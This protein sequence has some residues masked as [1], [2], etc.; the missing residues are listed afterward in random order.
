MKYGILQVPVF[1]ASFRL[2]HA[3]LI[4]AGITWPVL[5]LLAQ[6]TTK[7]SIEHADLLKLANENGTNFQVLMGNAVLRQD[8]TYFYCDTARLDEHNNLRASGKVHI[9]YNDSVHLYGDYL[10]YDGNTRIAVMDSNVRLIDNRA[11]LYTDN[12]EYNRNLSTANYYTG[13]RIED[14]ENVL[15]SKIGRY[16]TQTYEFLFSDSVVVVNPDYT[17]YADTLKY[18]TETEIVFI[19]GPTDLYGNEDHIY[20]EKGWYDTRTDRAELSRNNRIEHLEQ[21]LKGDWIYYDGEKEYGKAIGNVWIKDTVQNIILEGGISE[22][23]RGEK[24]SYM[25]DSARAI[26]VD[27][28]DSLYMHADSLI[29][30]MDSADNAKLMFAYNRMKFFKKD[31]QGMCDSLVFRVQDSIIALLK[32]PVIWSDENQ[33]TADSIWIHVSDNHIDSMVLFNLAFIISRDS[34]ETYNQIK[35]RQMRAYFRENQLYSIKV[36][37]NAE[38]IYYVREEDYDLIGINKSVSSNMMIMLEDRKPKKIYYL[39]KPEAT[40]YPV[41]DLKKEEQFLRDFKWIT[42]QRPANKNEIF[43]WEEAG[44]EN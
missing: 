6:K 14:K 43:T 28:D 31:L 42:G 26:L 9:N 15:T 11:I 5:P 39:S 1:M 18:N 8:S 32:N 37:G 25:T 7:V 29:M 33:L 3:C 40:L 10:T 27:T 41:K 4:L 16:F 38:T 17:V 19:E 12:L 44:S 35:G 21:I 34:I 13:G 23:Y 22:F 20:S 2:I 36:L 24:Y 30:V